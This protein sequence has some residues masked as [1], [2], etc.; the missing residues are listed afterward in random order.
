MLWNGAHLKC[1]RRSHVR[2]EINIRVL[3]VHWLAIL[4]ACHADPREHPVRASAEPA[5]VPSGEA[6]TVAGG[7]NQRSYTKETR[8]VSSGRM[9]CTTAGSGLPATL[10]GRLHH[11]C[12]RTC[13]SPPAPPPTGRPEN[14]SPRPGYCCWRHRGAADT[15]AAARQHCGDHGYALAIN[16]L[17]CTDVNPR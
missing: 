11:L 14:K 9:A 7:A 13:G 15:T 1:G 16:K 12:R 2:P 8:P 17:C 6:D 3:M 5:S 4:R 10:L